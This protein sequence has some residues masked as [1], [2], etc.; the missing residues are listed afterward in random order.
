MNRLS[1][2]C[3]NK[4]STTGVIDGNF[5]ELTATYIND[6]VYY[7]SNVALSTAI[8]TKVTPLLATVRTYTIPEKY[9]NKPMFLIGM[10]ELKDDP[11]NS[12]SSN[13]QSVLCLY[14]GSTKIAEGGTAEFYDSSLTE[15][16]QIFVPAIHSFSNN[17]LILKVQ[18]SNNTTLCVK[19]GLTIMSLEGWTTMD[20]TES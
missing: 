2:C 5:D 20:I 19:T 10:V 16:A 7:H 14:D 11:A 3:C 8:Q 15:V 6:N 13:G 12:I 4:R 17:T 9:L 1:N 18:N